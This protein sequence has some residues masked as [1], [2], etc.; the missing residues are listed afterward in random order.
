MQAEP[1]QTPELKRELRCEVTKVAE[2]AGQGMRKENIAQRGN[3]GICQESL[4][5]SSVVHVRKVREA[6][7]RSTPQNEK[8]Q[9]SKLTQG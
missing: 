6:R 8:S 3:S 4:K 1:T 9:C 2:V 7:E 5:F